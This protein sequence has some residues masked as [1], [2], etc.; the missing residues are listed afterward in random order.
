MNL[1][2]THHFDV[3]G[4]ILC[5]VGE[6]LKTLRVEDGAQSSMIGFGLEAT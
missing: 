6:L 5:F 4:Y 2:S 1:N 3:G